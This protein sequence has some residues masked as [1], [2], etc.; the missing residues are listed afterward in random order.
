M[1]AK[2]ELH[3]RRRFFQR[4]QKR[5]ERA[6]GEH[7]NFVD[8]ENLGARHQRVILCAL[9][10]LA[11]IV[12]AGVGGRVHL[13]HVGVAAFHDLG[14]VLPK[15]RHLNRGLVDSRRFIV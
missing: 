6:F 3:M 14:A 7:V 4:L 10:N 1:V 5:V 15:P 12:D 11:D 13:E 9:D 8:Q 2:N